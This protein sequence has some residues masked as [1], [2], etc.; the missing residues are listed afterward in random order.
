[1]GMNRLRQGKE[2]LLLFQRTDQAMFS[3]ERHQIGAAGQIDQGGVTHDTIDPARFVGDDKGW[4][5]GAVDKAMFGL[6]Q[7]G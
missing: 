5:Q 3:H 6:F 4:R 7:N 1:M 2:K